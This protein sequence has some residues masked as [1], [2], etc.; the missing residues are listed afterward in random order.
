MAGKDAPRILPLLSLLLVLALLVGCGAPAT[1]APTSAPKPAAPAA[2]TAP[3]APAAPAATTAP[4]APAATKAAATTAPAAPAA[5]TA[6]AATKAAATTGTAGQLAL[7]GLPTTPAANGKLRLGVYSLYLQGIDFNKVVANYNKFNP[8]VQVEII[9]IPGE[10]TAWQ[11]ITQKMQLEAQQNRA[12]WDI[13][14]GPTPFVEPGA[15]AEAGAARTPRYYR[16]AKR[17]GRRLQR[18]PNRDSLSRGTTRS[19]P[20]RCGAMYSA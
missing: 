3:A 9:A 2:T 10:E 11:A 18:G 15:L 16:A 14:F 6:P 19:T 7:A 5:T 1:T 17:V 12:S 4:A 8:N 20:S 13:L